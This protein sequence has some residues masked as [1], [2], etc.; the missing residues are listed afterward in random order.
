MIKPDSKLGAHMRGRILLLKR[1][2]GWFKK[3]CPN[4]EAWDT[5]LPVCAGDTVNGTILTCSSNVMGNYCPHCLH[6]IDWKFI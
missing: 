1:R 3:R 4:C 5:P 2:L 6:R